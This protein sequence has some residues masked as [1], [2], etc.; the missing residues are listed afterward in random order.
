MKPVH[1]LS[2]LII[3]LGNCLCLTKAQA[4]PPPLDA[5]APELTKTQTLHKNIKQ[6]LTQATSRHIGDKQT[7]KKK[8]I[9]DKASTKPAEPCMFPTLPTQY[10]RSPNN[11]FSQRSSTKSGAMLNRR[12]QRKNYAQRRES[13]QWMLTKTLDHYFPVFI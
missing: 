3:L 5:P 7:A 13:E 11:F 2:I 9:V 8:E 10:M 1:L 12:K 4:L 6:F